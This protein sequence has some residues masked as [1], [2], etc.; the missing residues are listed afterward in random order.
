M[1]QKQKILIWLLNGHKVTQKQ[2]I[3]RWHCYRLAARI[4]EIRKL[5]DV[6]TEMKGTKTKFA[7]YSM[8]V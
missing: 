5:F 2:A 4:E 1:S 8:E 6:R 3:A 7:E